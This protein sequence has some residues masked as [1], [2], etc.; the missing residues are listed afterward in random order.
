VRMTVNAD[1]LEL[2]LSRMLA[3]LARARG[4]R[5]RPRRRF[6]HMITIVATAIGLLFAMIPFVANAPSKTLP[7]RADA[8]PVL[9]PMAPE[10]VIIAPAPTLP[11]H[12]A[13]RPLPAREPGARDGYVSD[14]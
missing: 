12:R 4:E 8:A 10:S 1:E 9:V 3:E 14:L 5:L 11:L 6:E 7:Q 13:D 2:V